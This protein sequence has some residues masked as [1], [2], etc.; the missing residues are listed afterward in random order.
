MMDAIV[1]YAW[2]LGVFDLAFGLFCIICAAYRVITD[3]GRVIYDD[4]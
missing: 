2:M 1:R 4:D 3:S